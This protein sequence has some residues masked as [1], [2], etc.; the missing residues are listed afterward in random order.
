[1]RHR[2][3]PGPAR[4]EGRLI[5]KEPPVRRKV[6]FPTECPMPPPTL[7]LSRGPSLREPDFATEAPKEPPWFVPYVDRPN[8]DVSATN[9]RV[10]RQDSPGGGRAPGYCRAP[11]RSRLGRRLLRHLRRRLAVCA[12]GRRQLHHPLRRVAMSQVA[13][14]L[15]GGGMAGSVAVT[16]LFSATWPIAAIG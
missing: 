13:L 15:L 2:L 16:G 7:K 12:N 3:T 6:R 10:C 8:G 14:V 5:L 4:R 1:G 9:L 11:R